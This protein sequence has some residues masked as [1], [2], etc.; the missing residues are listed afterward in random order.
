M[1]QRT[2]RK[3]QGRAFSLLRVRGIDIIPSAIMTYRDIRQQRS[4]RN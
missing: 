4:Q 3:I 1:T 2:V